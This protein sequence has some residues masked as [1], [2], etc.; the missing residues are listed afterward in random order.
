MYEY[1]P[2]Q[3]NNV[4]CTREEIQCIFS[5]ADKDGTGQLNIKEFT[6]SKAVNMVKDAENNSAPKSP[7]QKR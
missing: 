1:F 2:P 6:S 3:E 7:G 5:G 4:P